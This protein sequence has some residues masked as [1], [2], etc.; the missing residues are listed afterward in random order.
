MLAG[1][2]ETN[3]GGTSSL[4]GS[5]SG[6]TGSGSG[7]AVSTLQTA[8]AERVVSPCGSLAMFF[9]FFS[10]FFSNIFCDQGGLRIFGPD[11]NGFCSI[12]HRSCMILLFFFIFCSESI[13]FFLIE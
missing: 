7:E 11:Q 13:A 12:E 4:S 9:F 3:V 10:I 2:L 6:S 5:G 8:V 1:L